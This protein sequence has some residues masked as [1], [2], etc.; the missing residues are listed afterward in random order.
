MFS[1]GGGHTCWVC[2]AR[3]ND[4]DTELDI[5]GCAQLRRGAAQVRQ[6]LHVLHHHDGTTPATVQRVVACSG[7]N[8]RQP[9]GVSDDEF[10]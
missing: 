4:V 1:A 9:A 7:S 2:A 8:S 10:R 3:G 6:H 5:M